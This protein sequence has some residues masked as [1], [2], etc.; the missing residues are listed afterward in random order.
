MFVFLLC[1]AF[2][3]VFGVRRA[4]GRSF[5]FERVAKLSALTHEIG[6]DLLD[7]LDLLR[8][9]LEHPDDFG[10]AQGGEAQVKILRVIQQREFERVGG[11]ETLR[12]DARLISATHR[13]LSK[14]V[15]AGRF[16]EDLY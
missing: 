5:G 14:E 4:K 8:V 11:T 9:K 6:Q 15:T 1:L 12:T 10:P 3:F 2:R 13:D 16:R 7:F